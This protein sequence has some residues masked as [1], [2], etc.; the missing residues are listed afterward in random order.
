MVHW[1]R[2]PSNVGGAGSIFG[3]EDGIPSASWSKGQ[4]KNKQTNKQ[5]KY[6]NKLNKDFK[7]GPHQKNT[8]KKKS[9]TIKLFQNKNCWARAPAEGVWRLSVLSTPEGTVGD[10]RKRGQGI[11]CVREE[12]CRA[13]DARASRTT[14]SGLTAPPDVVSWRKMGSP[15]SRGG[16]SWGSR[17]CCFHA[18]LVK[19]RQALV[20]EACKRLQCSF[21]C[22]ANLI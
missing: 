21:W 13:D 19:I 15:L 4:S 10:G 5:K 7:N 20:Q 3:L 6:C 11:W 18:E 9:R 1:L 14:S 22:L 2:L 8:L 16:E 17:F 12:A